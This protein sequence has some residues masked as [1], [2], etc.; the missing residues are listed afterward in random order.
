MQTLEGRTCVFAGATGQIGQGAVRALAMGGM[1]VVMVTHNPDTAKEIIAGMQGL[2]GKVTAMS[3]ANGDGAVFGDIEKEFG[4]VDV[5]IN[6]IGSLDAPVPVQEI[7]GE[8]LSDKLN[9]QVV[10]PFLM[11]QAAIPYL[12]RSK[13][14]RIIFASTAGAQD[15]FT[16]ENMADSIA[17]GGVLTATYCLARELATKGITVNC[18]A[19]TGLIDDHA[20]HSPKDFEVKTIAERIPVGRI[21]TADEF[22]ARGIYRQ[23]GVGIC[24][25]SDIQSVRRT[26]YRITQG[27][28][29]ENC[30]PS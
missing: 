12:E 9:H 16:G 23:R 17:R 22:G 6:T 15:G 1:N 30:G 27:S 10:L 24:H 8:L 29:H 11:V 25:R 13:A 26:S 28:V 5:V 3:N 20:P 7:S 18:I 19:R 4:S 21:G 2:P 14:P